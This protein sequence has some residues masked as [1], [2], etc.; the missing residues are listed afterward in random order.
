MKIREILQ[1]KQKYHGRQENLSD[2]VAAALPG[3]Y[4]QRQLRNTDPYLQYR[5]GMAVA[6][7]RAIANGELDKNS[8]DQESAFAENLTQVLYSDQDLE[9]IQL[10]SSLMG[11][12]PTAIDDTPSREDRSV[13]SLSPV[14]QIKRN[15]YGI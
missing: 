5:Y 7:A 3:V 10:A 2:Q 4:V 8:Y 14:P 13:N 9:T 1:E 6:A 12:T 15:K 11:V